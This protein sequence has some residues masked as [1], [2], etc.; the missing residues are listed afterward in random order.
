MSVPTEVMN[1]EFCEAIRKDREHIVRLVSLYYTD[2]LKKV[3]G[4]RLSR[5]VKVD[6]L[7]GTFSL[8]YQ[9]NANGNDRTFMWRTSEQD[10]LGDGRNVVEILREQLDQAIRELDDR[11]GMSNFDASPF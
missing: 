8:A 9:I 11:P 10:L 5:P 2:V 4:M 3:P 7:A 6:L 1:N